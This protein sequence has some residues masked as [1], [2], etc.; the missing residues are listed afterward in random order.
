MGHAALPPAAHRKIKEQDEKLSL[1]LYFCATTA[2]FAFANSGRSDVDPSQVF[3][4]T[5]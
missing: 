2:C 4:S 3:T 1:G 5:A